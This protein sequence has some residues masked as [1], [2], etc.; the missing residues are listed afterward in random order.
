MRILALGVFA[1][2]VAVWGCQSPV[3]TPT[4]AA[5]PAAAL[6]AV[7]S[8]QSVALTLKS[9]SPNI[10]VICEGLVK[11]VD[12]ETIVIVNATRT[13]RREASSH[14]SGLLPFAGRVLR[15]AGVG[16][17]TLPGE[18]TLQRGDLVSIILLPPPPP[19]API[20]RHVPLP[21]DDAMSGEGARD[22]V[23]G[24]IRP[25]IIDESEQ[26]SALLTTMP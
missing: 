21:G 22:A 15:N 5:L 17:E 4:P 6:P 2:M 19:S 11:A 23:L 18:V 26:A 16:V 3:T 13:T 14:P 24:G 12:D 25:R 1:S 9:E 10:T 7:V 20:H 8:G